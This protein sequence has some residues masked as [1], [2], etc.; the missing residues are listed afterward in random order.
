MYWSDQVK[1]SNYL[2]F[3]PLVKDQMASHWRKTLQDK[4]FR[5]FPLRNGS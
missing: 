2:V 1:E 4:E 3:L 5:A